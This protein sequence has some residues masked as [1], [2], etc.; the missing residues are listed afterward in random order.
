MAERRQGL[1]VA[2]RDGRLE[3]INLSPKDTERL[4][5]LTE[6]LGVAKTEVGRRAIKLYLEASDSLVAE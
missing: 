3:V 2:Q 4:D 1:T 5:R 6:R